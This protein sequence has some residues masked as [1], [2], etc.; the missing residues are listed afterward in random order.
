MPDKFLKSSDFRAKIE[1]FFLLFFNS[2]FFSPEMH[3][4]E[5]VHA[6]VIFGTFLKKIARI[7]VRNSCHKSRLYISIPK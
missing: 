6:Y 2:T 1:E 5:T 4:G 7:P 3:R